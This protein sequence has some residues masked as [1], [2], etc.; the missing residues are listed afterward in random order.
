MLVKNPSH[1]KTINNNQIRLL[2]TIFKFR[3][4]T[5]PLL[6]DY[7]V[8]DRSTVYE[9]LMT[10]AS[11]GYVSKAYDSSY[12]LPAR[13]ATYSLAAKAI[14]YLRQT[15]DI[16]PTGLKNQ[17][18]N[19]AASAQLV[20]QSLIAFKLC[21][22]LRRHYPDQF[23]SFAKSELNDV[24]GFVRPL[25]AMYLRRKLVR[26]DESNEYLLELL[27][28]GVPSWLL[29]KRLRAHCNMADELDYRYPDVLFVCANLSTEHRLQQIVNSMLPDTTFWTTT[30][31][32]LA[33]DVRDIWCAAD[34]EPDDDPVYC[35]L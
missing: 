30:T 18:Q 32:R 7:L 19:R 12:R 14:T 9:Q 26:V 22:Q 29:R 27:P 3:Y 15:T 33:S 34:T 23:D 25:S 13:P 17:Y 2:K 24:D 11:Q 21:I 35:Q 8:K 31:E 28:F 10:L 20:E 5:V 1:R 16:S 6:A 4:T